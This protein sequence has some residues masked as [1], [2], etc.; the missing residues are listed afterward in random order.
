LIETGDFHRII[1]IKEMS[2]AAYP[3]SV[4]ATTQAQIDEN[5]EVIVG[6]LAAYVNA[7]DLFK[8]DPETAKRV[9][10][11]FLKVDDEEE[12]DTAHQVFSE[13]F[14]DDPTPQA[15][16]FNTV[17]EHIA[18][19]EGMDIEGVD[20]SESVNTELIQEAMERARG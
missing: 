4:T 20:L 9:L 1:D 10:S 8:E 12:L 2:E 18:E 17:L 3:S 19:V 15:E 7:I 14:Q 11:E 13:I 6:A 5:R 16:H